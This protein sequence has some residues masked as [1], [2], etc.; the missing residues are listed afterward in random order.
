[1][2]EFLPAGLGQLVS[3][4]EGYGQCDSC[5]QYLCGPDVNTLCVFLSLPHTATSECDAVCACCSLHAL[6]WFTR[7]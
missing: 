6:R 3:L 1:M 4:L 5:A 2:L 7:S